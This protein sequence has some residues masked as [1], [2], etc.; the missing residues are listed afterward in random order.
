MYHAG[1]LL[2]A[3]IATAPAPDRLARRS[4]SFA[5]LPMVAG[6][7]VT[8]VGVELVIAHPFGHT[9]PAWIAVIVDGS[10]LFV[11]GRALFEYQA[12]GRVSRDRL[13]GLLVLAALTPAGGTG[14]AA[15]RV[16]L[17]TA[18]RPPPTRRL[19]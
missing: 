17:T 18:C 5:H 13:I 14:P 4:E 9:K 3:A 10:S 11:A 19:P 7:I 2:P 8:A 1:Q 6:I 12:F 16:T 15:L